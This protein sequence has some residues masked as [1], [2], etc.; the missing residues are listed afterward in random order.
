MLDLNKQL[1]EWAHDPKLESLLELLI[2][3]MNEENGDATAIEE[4]RHHFKLVK[5]MSKELEALMELAARIAESVEALE[6]QT[7]HLLS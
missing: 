7:E 2:D 3:Y 1:E 6:D 5:N 4:L